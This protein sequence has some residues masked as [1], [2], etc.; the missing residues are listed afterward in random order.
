M[1]DD[2]SLSLFFPSQL[3]QIHFLCKT[4]VFKRTARTDACQVFPDAPKQWLHS[5]QI[6]LILNLI[7]HL[8]VA[9][10]ILCVLASQ[11]FCF[12]S[13]L[14][15][16]LPSSPAV[17]VIWVYR[18]GEWCS[19]CLQW[20]HVLAARQSLFVSF[21]DI[22]KLHIKKSMEAWTKFY[23]L[24]LCEPGWSIAVLGSKVWIG[25]SIL[26]TLEWKCW[27]SCMFSP[28]LYA[29]HFQEHIMNF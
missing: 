27:W 3:N 17:S 16:S 12:L 20:A 24:W 13:S 6:P 29:N 26:Q 25:V 4:T 23:T 28:K 8:T 22:W 1:M 7:R 10:S 19:V 15:L 5:W 21:T 18:P 14:P 11:P 9:Y 2:F